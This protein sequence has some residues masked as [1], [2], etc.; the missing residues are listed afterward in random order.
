M[1]IISGKHRGRKLL[2]LDG[3]DITRPTADRVK[4]S[5]FNI[6]STKVIDAVVLDMFA[7]SGALGLESLSRGAKE[8]VFIDSDK[9]AADIVK[10]NISLCGEEDKSQVINL[11]YKVAL[12]KLEN[13]KFDLVF[14]DPPY[15]KDIETI[16]LGMLNDKLSEDAIVVVEIDEKDDVQDKVG[17]LVK[18]DSRKYGRTI[19]S[20]FKQEY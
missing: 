18:C 2:T 16:A 9:K 12:K 7:G 11:D 13:K 19:I 5:L 20:F 10:K 3:F 4:E 8:C 14:I 1:R 17:N 15:S 6:L